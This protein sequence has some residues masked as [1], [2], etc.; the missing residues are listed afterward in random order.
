[1]FEVWENPATQYSSTQCIHSSEADMGYTIRFWWAPLALLSEYC[2]ETQYQCD[3]G[4]KLRE[5]SV[6][7]SFEQSIYKSRI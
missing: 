3:E 2:K 7:N 1:M 4:Q 5:N 6:M